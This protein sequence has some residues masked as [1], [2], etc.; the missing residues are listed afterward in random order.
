M[1]NFNIFMKYIVKPVLR[2]K[3]SFK[4]GLLKKIKFI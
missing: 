3:W 2:K 1:Y 4:R